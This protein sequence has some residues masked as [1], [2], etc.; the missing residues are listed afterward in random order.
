M[1]IYHQITG[2]YNLALQPRIWDMPADT[3]RTLQLYG[4]KNHS[5]PCDIILYK[6]ALL[7]Q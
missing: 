3:Q 1:T 2:D 4:N 7:V 6:I 5:S